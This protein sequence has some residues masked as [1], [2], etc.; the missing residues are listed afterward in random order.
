MRDEKFSKL[1]IPING[2]LHAKIVRVH[3]KIP[4]ALELNSSLH[5]LNFHPNLSLQKLFSPD[6]K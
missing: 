4:F 6:F 1:I 3:E 2:Y 5:L